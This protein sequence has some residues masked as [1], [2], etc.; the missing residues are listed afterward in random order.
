[1]T[2]CFCFIPRLQDSTKGTASVHLDDT[3]C[4]KADMA[5][6]RRLV[7]GGLGVKPSLIE[8]TVA[9]IRIDGEISDTER[10]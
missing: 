6:T 5:H 10:G 7:F 3:R 4:G 8:S 2:V 1:M 9:A